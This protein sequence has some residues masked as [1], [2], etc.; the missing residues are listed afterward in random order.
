MI[1]TDNLFSLAK[2]TYKTHLQ[3][4]SQQDQLHDVTHHKLPSRMNYIAFIFS[5]FMIV[6]RSN[7]GERCSNPVNQSVNGLLLICWTVYRDYHSQPKIHRTRLQAASGLT[8]QNQTKKNILPSISLTS[9]CKLHPKIWLKFQVKNESFTHPLM[10][11]TCIL[12]Y[13][14]TVKYESI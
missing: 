14:F 8:G 13:L 7:S 2:S 11:I 12:A 1:Q 5:I 3:S 10:N 4:M 6:S 9:A